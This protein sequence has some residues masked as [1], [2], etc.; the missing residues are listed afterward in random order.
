MSDKRKTKKD[1][2]YTTRFTGVNI[3]IIRTF[4]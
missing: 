3:N 2:N 4:L 1:H